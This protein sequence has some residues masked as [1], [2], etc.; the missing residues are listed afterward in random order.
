MVELLELFNNFVEFVYVEKDRYN[1]FWEV[2]ML[3]E[4]WGSGKDIV[5]CDIFV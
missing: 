3:F 1:S 2:V 5:S 4:L